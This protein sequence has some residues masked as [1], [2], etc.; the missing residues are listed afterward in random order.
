MIEIRDKATLIPAMVIRVNAMTNMPE[1]HN[2]LIQHSGWGTDNP[3]IYLFA[4]H[5][6]GYCHYDA[7]G[8]GDRTFHNA[9]LY[10]QEHF[11]DIEDGQ[12]VD[13]EFILG[14]TEHPKVPTQDRPF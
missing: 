10:V 2:W 8:W 9:H 3:G 13:V 14:E 6:K 7:Y 1:P 5:G 12:V 4:M 11:D